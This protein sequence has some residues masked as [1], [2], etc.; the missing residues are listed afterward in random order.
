ML[1]ESQ[2]V[3]IN[4]EL[5]LINLVLSVNSKLNVFIAEILLVLTYSRCFMTCAH[6]GVELLRAQVASKIPDWFLLQGNPAY[7]E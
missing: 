1:F 3:I 6:E 5:L 2:H 4:C 7:A